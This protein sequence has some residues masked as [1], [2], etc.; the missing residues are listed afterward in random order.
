[1]N[2]LLQ[3]RRDTR[4]VGQ[5]GYNALRHS[6][7]KHLKVIFILLFIRG[8]KVLA[9]GDNFIWLLTC[10]Q[11]IIKWGPQVGAFIFIEELCI[12]LDFL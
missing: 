5:G 8:L 11:F 2:G 3:D 6:S 10:F 9:W 12:D 7:L 1:M 4:D